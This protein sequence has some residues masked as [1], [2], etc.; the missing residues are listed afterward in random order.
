MENSEPNNN[1]PKGHVVRKLAETRKLFSHKHT[2]TLP[3]NKN[4]K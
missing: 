4:K 3:K 2:H 1:N